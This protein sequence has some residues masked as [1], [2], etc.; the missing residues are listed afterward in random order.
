MKNV[1]TERQFEKEV[2]IAITA[3]V[4][5]IIALFVVLKYADDIDGVVTRKVV[6]DCRLAEISPDF[7]P[8]VRNECRKLRTN[9]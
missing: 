7:P 4:V 8:D 3:I 5:A 6:Y 1:I 9:K 2:I